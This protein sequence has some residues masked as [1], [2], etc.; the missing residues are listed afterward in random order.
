M[1]NSFAEHFLK[2]AEEELGKGNQYT[3]AIAELYDIWK[4]TSSVS[5]KLLMLGVDALYWQGMEEKETVDGSAEKFEEEE[6]DFEEQDDYDLEMGFNPYIGS[7]D[8]DC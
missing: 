2:K 7:Y 5:S 6:G 3:R 4:N 8:F 1:T